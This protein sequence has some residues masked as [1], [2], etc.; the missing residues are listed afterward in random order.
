MSF[1]ILFPFIPALTSVTPGDDNIS[2]TSKGI[3]K[4]KDILT[5]KRQ[6]SRV[7]KSSK[8]DIY[9]PFWIATPGINISSWCQSKC[10]FSSNCHI[11]NDHASQDRDLL[12]SIVITSTTLR[13]AYQP[14]WRTAR[15][16]VM[17]FVFCKRPLT[18]CIRM[19]I[20]YIAWCKNCYPSK[21]HQ[22]LG[23]KSEA[24]PVWNVNL[25]IYREN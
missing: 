1:H 19:T 15:G 6:I 18:F 2:C 16:S 10:V 8:Y 21:I 22:V 4:Y 23:N 7:C 5:N 24:I 17:K 9:L 25:F 20:M 3:I 12:G 11:F 14:V 13:Q